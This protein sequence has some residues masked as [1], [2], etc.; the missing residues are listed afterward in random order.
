[1]FISKMNIPWEKL[2]DW[3]RSFVNGR[4]DSEERA[5]KPLPGDSFPK[6]VVRNIIN[7]AHK[8]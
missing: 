2:T 1:M 4:I 7:E 8:R 5:K 6:V 3:E